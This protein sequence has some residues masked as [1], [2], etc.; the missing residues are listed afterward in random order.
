MKNK[1]E[2][3]KAFHTAFKLGYSESPLSDLGQDKTMLRYNLMKEENEEYLEAA[4]NKDL[5]EIADA[6]GD[7][8]YILCGTI[9]EHGLQHKI[10]DVFNEI[11]RSNMSKLDANGEPIYRAD[12]KVLKGPNYFNPDLVSILEK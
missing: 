1:I 4:N 9:I 11:Q 7:M 12:G 6:L 8:L 5:V 3:V 2:A 10:E